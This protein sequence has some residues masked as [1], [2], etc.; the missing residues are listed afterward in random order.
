M[1]VILRKTHSQVK[2]DRTILAAVKPF[3]EAE[4]RPADAAAAE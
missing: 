1:F 2:I 3:P 4:Q